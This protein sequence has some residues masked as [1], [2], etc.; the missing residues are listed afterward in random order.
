VEEGL[1]RTLLPVNTVRRKKKVIHV[2]V[3]CIEVIEEKVEGI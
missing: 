2:F 3:L 1:R